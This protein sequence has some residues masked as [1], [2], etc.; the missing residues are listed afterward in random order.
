MHV[1]QFNESNF[2]CLHLWKKFLHLVSTPI[3]P[4]CRDERQWSDTVSLYFSRLTFIV[5]CM[6][7]DGTPGCADEGGIAVVVQC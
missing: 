5:Q 3:N 2:D 7:T 6:G 4:K 1:M